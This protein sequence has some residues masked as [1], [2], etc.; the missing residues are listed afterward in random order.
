MFA[1]LMKISHPL[2]PGR[3]LLRAWQLCNK[4]VAAACSFIDR[5]D[6][7]VVKDCAVTLRALVPAA[8][9]AHCLPVRL[10]FAYCCSF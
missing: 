6:D 7:A 1:V 8:D 5:C 3:D 4:L 2:V 10:F 9:G